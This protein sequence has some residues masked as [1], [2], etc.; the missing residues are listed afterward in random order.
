MT[1]LPRVI[2][3][4]LLLVGLYTLLWRGGGELAAFVV[5]MAI[6]ML[7]FSFVP[8]DN[9]E[10]QKFKKKYRY[11]EVVTVLFISTSISALVAVAFLEY[12]PIIVA[13]VGLAVGV[14]LHLG[15]VVQQ[16]VFFSNSN[17]VRPK[18]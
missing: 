14:L 3:L 11:D 8:E 10:F 6:S 13:N 5:I 12:D 2:Q 1:I 16:L 4:A 7:L 17:S 15:I 18:E 9:I